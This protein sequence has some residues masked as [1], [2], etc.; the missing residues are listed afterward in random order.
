MLYRLITTTLD[1]YGE[2]EASVYNTIGI[3]MSFILPN[4]LRKDIWLKYEWK[5]YQYKELQKSQK[6]IKIPYYN[7][8]SYFLFKGT[9]TVLLWWFNM[10]Y[11]I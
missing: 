4:Q 11:K 2:S 8:K 10:E 9:V 5:N 6:K 1:I 3:K 7:M